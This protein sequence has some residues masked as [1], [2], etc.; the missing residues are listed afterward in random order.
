MT[1]SKPDQKVKD[2]LTQWHKS[3]DRQILLQ[4]AQ[5]GMKNQLDFRALKTWA[6]DQNMEGVVT[7]LKKGIKQLKREEAEKK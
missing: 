1:D 7:D 5:V 2:R 4:A 6:K 3:K